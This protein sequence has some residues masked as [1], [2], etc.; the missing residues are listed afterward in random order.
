[1]RKLVLLLLLVPILSLTQPPQGGLIVKEMK[2]ENVNLDT[3]LKALIKITGKNIL[4]D[5]SIQE[6]KAV[7]VA[8]KEWSYGRYFA[9]LYTYPNRMS[10]KVNIFISKPLSINEAMK[11]IMKEFGLIAVPIDKDTYKITTL[12]K[13][14]IGITNMRD[15]D[16]N[17]FL[18]LIKNKVTPSAEVVIDKKSGLILVSDSF[19]RVEYLFSSL[20]RYV[21]GKAQDSFDIDIAGF[22][23]K[24]IAQVVDLL[25][26]KFP[27]ADINV[28]KRLGFIR[29]YANKEDIASLKLYID[30]YIKTKFRHKLKERFTTR[31]FFL[32]DIVST[33]EAIKIL[34]PHISPETLITESPTF[35]ALVIR[36]KLSKINSYAKILE[37]FLKEKPTSR[38][39]VTQIFYLKYITPEEFMKMIEPLRS[40]AGY[41]LGGEERIT[42]GTPRV[43][44]IEGTRREGQMGERVEEQ[45]TGQDYIRKA[46]GRVGET[47]IYERRKSLST[48]LADFN[49][50]MITDYPEVIER[51]KERF[52]QYISDVPVQVKI[53]AKILEVRK[54]VLREIGIGANVLASKAKVPGFWDAGAGVN[55]DVL[56][57]PTPDLS[58]NPGT[59]LTLTLQ[60]GALNALNLKLSA[61]EKIGKIKNIAK[62][63]VI[64]VNGKEAIIKQGE[65]L[66]YETIIPVVGG[67]TA[68][69]TINWK[70]IV[71][72]LR[73]I[74]LIS[75]DDKI[76]L[77]IVITYDTPGR[78]TPQ[79]YLGINTKEIRTR[80]VVHHGDTLVIGGVLEKQNNKTNEG[81][82]K[83]VRVPLLKWL[84]G[85]EKFEETD[86]ELLIFLTPI[87]LRE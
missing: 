11:L 47:V 29:I 54:E 76:M 35:N 21:Q 23:D 64:T 74:P 1:M 77:D 20:E 34:E 25:K 12:A 44:R 7:D 9:K 16:V 87:V 28:D 48:I 17:E 26:Q 30:R 51:I 72:E 22:E 53:E 59:I 61:Y 69:P 60:Q 82:P 66:P 73:V 78:T 3:V 62:P 8:K 10:Q 83:L 37:K 13:L 86:K 32:K 31:V 75:P 68:V 19:D 50:V 36:D 4:I 42:G 57:S 45:A 65:E 58:Q 81:V 63:T 67:G 5:P 6:G 15:K 18:D 71:L 41:I 55:P 49:A 2:F 27:N 84:L 24:D 14:E 85:Q 43:Q 39:P 79:G 38:K 70:E 46:G 40:E 80:A 52:S 56:L 33:D